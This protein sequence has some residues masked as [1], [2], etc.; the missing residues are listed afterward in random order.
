[1]L[2]TKNIGAY[3]VVTGLRGQVCEDLNRG[4][5]G[6]CSHNPSSEDVHAREECL[7]LA[8]LKPSSVGSRLCTSA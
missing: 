8:Y 4:E 6:P 7:Q 3:H 2:E 5:D 1:M